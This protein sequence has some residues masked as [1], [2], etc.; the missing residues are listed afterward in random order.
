MLVTVIVIEQKSA[1]GIVA[2]CLI[3]NTSRFIHQKLKLKVNSDKSRYGAVTESK[4]LGFRFNRQY[5][6]IHDRA[7]QGFKIKVKKLTNRNKGISMNQQIHQLNQYL[8]GWGNYFLIANEYQ[9]CLDLDH[10]IRHRLRM[11]FWRQWRKPR[12]KIKN[13]I[14][15]GVSTKMA[16][17]CGITSKDP[18]RSS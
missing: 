9:L 11:C 10:W 6:K 3:E 18:W 2:K 1:D 16:I 7:I 12:T 4:F 5:I 8:R 17:D 14:N 15:F 13:L